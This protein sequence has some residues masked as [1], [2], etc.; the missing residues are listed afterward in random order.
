MR[1]IEGK[2][3]DCYLSLASQKTQSDKCIKNIGERG[4]SIDNLTKTL[5][6]L[7]L[8][9]DYIRK[10]LEVKAFVEPLLAY[11]PRRTKDFTDHAIIHSNNLLKILAA[12][13]ENLGIKQLREEERF[14]FCLAIYM[15]DLGC[16]ID[17]SKHNLYSAKILGHD[18]F[19]FIESKIGSDIMECVKYLALSHSSNY[20]LEQLPKHKIHSNVRL[21]LTCA[22]FR[23]IDGCDLM[24]ERANPVLYDILMKYDPLE[25]DS[26]EIW[27]AHSNVAG[28][29][30][31]KNAIVI[32]TRNKSSTNVL[33]EHLREDLKDINR[34]F[35]VYGLPKF[36]VRVKKV[37]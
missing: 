8:T 19:K 10:V 31:E 24:P 4:R 15:H 35:C 14:C 36:Q 18:R 3:E 25:P 17:R 22:I 12:F 23:L 34:V 33:T 6:Q 27:H 32:S 29:V 28:V 9:D 1:L 11:L 5:K 30:F 2:L 20:H 21:D 16:L 7:R 37:K 26:Q 13:V